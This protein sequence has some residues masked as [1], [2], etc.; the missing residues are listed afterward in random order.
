VER[1]SKSIVEGHYMKGLEE[2]QFRGNYLLEKRSTC[3]A[4][5][6]LKIEH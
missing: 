5:F 1:Q 4:F 2:S 6:I 3:S